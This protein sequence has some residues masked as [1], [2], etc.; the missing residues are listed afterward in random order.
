MQC[1]YVGASLLQALQNEIK[2]LTW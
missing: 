2:L 1:I